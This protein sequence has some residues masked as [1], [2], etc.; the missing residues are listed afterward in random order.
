MCAFSRSSN[1]NRSSCSDKWWGNRT[2]KEEE[3]VVGLVVEFDVGLRATLLTI[4]GGK[5]RKDVVARR[6][7]MRSRDKVQGID[8]FGNK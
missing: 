4:G 5:K 2:A 3:V 6:G 8:F 1:N 7:V